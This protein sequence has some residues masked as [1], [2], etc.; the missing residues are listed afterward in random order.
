MDVVNLIGVDPGIVDTGVVWVRMDRENK[1]F[2]VY[3]TVYHNVTRKVKGGIEVDQDFLDSLKN[4]VLGIS[5]L[6]S[7]P[8]FVFIEGYRNRGRNPGQD[9]KMTM[10]VQS[11]HRVLPGSVVVDNTGVKN[12]VTDATLDLLGLK[13]WGIATHHADLKSAARILLKG[14]YQND[15]LNHWIAD[16]VRDSLED[17]AWT[18]TNSR[19]F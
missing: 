6:S 4:Y 19:G 16:V 14:A 13:H 15:G 7:P 10:L 11:I 12:V 8:A 2:S 18:V 17:K 5:V 9:Q 1:T 3:P